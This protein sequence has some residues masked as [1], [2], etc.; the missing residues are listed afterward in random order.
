MLDSFCFVV[1]RSLEKV[2]LVWG[3]VFSLLLSL[4]S[5]E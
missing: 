4:M 1:L 5:D 2:F 3:L